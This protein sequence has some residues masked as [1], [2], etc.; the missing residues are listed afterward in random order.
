MKNVLLIFL[1]SFLFFSCSESIKEKKMT[2]SNIQKIKDSKE[3]TQKEKELFATYLIRTNLKNAFSGD[4]DFLI[5]STITIGE[6]IKKQKEW[7]IEDSIKTANEQKAAEEAFQKKQLQIQKLKNIVTVNI[8][9]KSFSEADYSK[10]NVI[11]ISINNNS[12]STI[13]GVKG[14]LKISDMFGDAISNLEVKYDKIL[15]PKERAFNTGYYD[16]NQFMD[17]DTKL[18]FTELEKMKVVWEPEM[19]IFNDG[20]KLVLG[21]E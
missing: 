20:S 1:M 17:R 13:I 18:K 10:Y 7:V 16:Y 5:D 2:Q 12:D 11:T 6:A 8:V 3:L 14:T 21:D 4:K 9:R 15:K 19:I